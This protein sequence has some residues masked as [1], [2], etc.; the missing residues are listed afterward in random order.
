MATVQTI[1]ERDV[2]K[3]ITDYLS[4]EGIW[5]M[6]VNSGAV[7]AEH[8]GRSRFFRFGQ[9]GMADILC[10]PKITHSLPDGHIFLKEVS[11][12]LARVP[13]VLWIEVKRPGGKQSPEQMRFQIECLARGHGYLLAECVEDIMDWLARHV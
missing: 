10:T 13:V 2:Q 4:A 1:R 9:P 5:W 3:C 12:N 7:K 6:R 11:G 8:N